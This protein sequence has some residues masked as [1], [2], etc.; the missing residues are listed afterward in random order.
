M[1]KSEEL[2]YSPGKIIILWQLIFFVSQNEGVR[3]RE[4][5]GLINAGGI[6]GGTI[7]ID[8][9]LRLAGYCRF[10]DLKNGKVYLIEEARNGLLPLC[11]FAYPNF[12]IISF[13]I[14]NTFASYAVETGSKT[15]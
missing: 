15:G 13:V 9:A 1:T 8:A 12:E 11:S 3:I 10:L 7:P 5:L 2:N 14:H 4:I 6:M